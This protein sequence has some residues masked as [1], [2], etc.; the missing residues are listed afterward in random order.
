MDHGLRPQKKFRHASKLLHRLRV[1][2]FCP[3]R[4]AVGTRNHLVFINISEDRLYQNGSRYQVCVMWADQRSSLPNNCFSPLVQL[5]SLERRLDKNPELEKSFA[6]A[7]LS[8][9][10][11]SYIVKIGKFCFTVDCFH[12]GYLPQHLNFYPHKPGK[13]RRVLN[14][15]AMFHCSSSNNALLTEPDSLQNLFQVFNRFRENQ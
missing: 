9:L 10:E 15:E 5:E 2:S 8:D 12:E 11:K 6:Q 1:T 7:I 4:V 13:I 3:I 14:R